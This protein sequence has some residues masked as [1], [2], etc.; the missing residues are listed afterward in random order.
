MPQHHQKPRNLEL[1][2]PA[3]STTKQPIPF[4]FSIVSELEPH[5]S[6]LFHHNILHHLI[7]YS[8]NHQVKQSGKSRGSR[9]SISQVVEIY[10]PAISSCFGRVFA[11]WFRCFGFFVKV[12]GASRSEPS[13]YFSFA[14]PFRQIN[15]QS[16]RDSPSPTTSIY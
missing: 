1:D 2:S 12:L 13:P 16:R 4:L 6:S 14:P 7:H 3:N 10:S 9:G 5:S 11:W 8:T 15:I